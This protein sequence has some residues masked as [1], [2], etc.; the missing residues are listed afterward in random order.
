MVSYD[1]EAVLI[2]VFG[3]EWGGGELW[4][5]YESISNPK[6]FFSIFVY[7]FSVMFL[8]LPGILYLVI[9]FIEKDKKDI[10]TKKK[11][12]VGHYIFLGS[13][14]ILLGIIIIVGYHFL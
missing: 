10:S 14:L 11:K 2:N 5:L 3:D 4:D 1:T 7:I 13:G 8:I 9:Y 6:Q 12:E